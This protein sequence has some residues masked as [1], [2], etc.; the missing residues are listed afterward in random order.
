MTFKGKKIRFAEMKNLI[1]LFYLLF[2]KKIFKYV[3]YMNICNVI[4]RKGYGNYLSN[5]CERN[6]LLIQ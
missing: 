4:Q 5:R 6:I 2:A 3:Q 1:T